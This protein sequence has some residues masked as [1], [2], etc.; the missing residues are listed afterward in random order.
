MLGVIH[1]RLLVCRGHRFHEHKRNLFYSHSQRFD[2]NI[3]VNAISTN[4]IHFY[5]LPVG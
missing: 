4:E 1:H 3:R 2:R 5:I